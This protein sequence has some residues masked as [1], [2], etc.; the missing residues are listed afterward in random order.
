MNEMKRQTRW[1]HYSHLVDK[2][3][4][5]VGI[6]SQADQQET[7]PQALLISR[8]RLLLAL[9]VI[10]VL[11]FIARLLQ[12]Q[13]VDGAL[14]PEVPANPVAA[15]TSRGRIADRNGLLLATDMFVMEVYGS[16]DKFNSAEDSALLVSVGEITEVPLAKLEAL[17]TNDVATITL[18]KDATD[19]QCE[20]IAALNRQDLFWCDR[21][22]VRG[23]PLGGLAAHM[24]GFCN[25]DMVGVYGVEDSYDGWLTNDPKW[26]DRKLPGQ[27]QPLPEGWDL[28]LPSPGGHDLVLN[29]NAP[30]QHMVERRLAEGLFEHGAEAGTIIV[31]DPRDGALLA[32]ANLPSFDP[33]HHSDVDLETWV[34]SAVGQIYEPGSI[35]KLI[36]MAA[37]LDSGMLTPETIYEDT[38]RLEVSSRAIYNAEHLTYGEVTVREALAKSL[39]VITAQICLDMG[40]ETF[41]RYVR[42][43]GFGSLTEVDLKYEG[44]GIVK[45]PG[46]PLW[47]YFDQ[48]ANSFGQGISVT[49]L[50]M[51]NAVAAIAN[52][53]K[54]YQPRVAQGLI[55]DGQVHHIPPK[56]VRRPISAET[57][58]TLTEMMVY[59]VDNYSGPDLVPGYRVAGKTGTA[60]IPTEEGYTSQETITSFVGF[61]PAA[62]PQLVILVKLVRPESSRW[63]EKVAM[64]IFGQ[65]AQDAVG[66]LGIPPDNRTP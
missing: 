16:P 36:T 59:T 62:D 32:L 21:I 11:I 27:P 46:N 7:D 13:V 34:N 54:L 48:A 31:M 60:E 42:Q 63:A 44:Y 18:A 9:F 30:L 41:Y 56:V 53:G 2:T 17:I 52:G 37:A 1:A 49:T 4:V 5:N 57:A 29:L 19:D 23:Y 45:E 55:L 40:A 24:L 50:Q 51:T 35:F 38:G 14:T 10:I 33:N 3:A 6:D 22:R 64:P 26:S 58:K 66:V 65:V 8:A 28:Y 25:Y 61:L 15:T 39:N 12:W 43:F 20:A 47:S